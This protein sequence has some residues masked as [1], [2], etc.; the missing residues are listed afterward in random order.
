M[1]KLRIINMSM[2]ANLALDCRLMWILKKCAVCVLSARVSRCELQNKKEAQQ[3]AKVG[4]VYMLLDSTRLHPVF[5]SKQP[6]T[7]IG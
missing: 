3:T 6:T 2:Q 1:I 4:I 7:C 5:T